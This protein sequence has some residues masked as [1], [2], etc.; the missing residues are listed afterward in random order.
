MVK[1]TA[2]GSVNILRCPS[3]ALL[4]CFSQS[5]P[6]EVPDICPE[7][8]EWSR[9]LTVR[10]C[11]RQAAEFACGDGPTNL[12]KESICLV[13]WLATVCLQESSR[14]KTEHDRL[15]AGVFMAL[16][17]M[18]RVM[19]AEGLHLSEEAR[20]RVQHWNSVYHCCINGL[21]AEAIEESRFLWK[22]RPK[23]HQNPG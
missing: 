23:M 16:A 11:C 20:S 14:T 22:L 3:S 1:A 8:L 9:A 6:W 5:C 4:P 13:R 7:A 2:Q 18:R 10:D 15:R 21:A 17:A 12:A 19:S